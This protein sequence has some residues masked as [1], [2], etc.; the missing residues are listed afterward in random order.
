MNSSFYYGNT[1]ISPKRTKLLVLIRKLLCV[2]LL[3]LIEVSFFLS[4]VNILATPIVGA[5]WGRGCKE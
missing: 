2:I 4:Y 3:Q 5:G 1:Y